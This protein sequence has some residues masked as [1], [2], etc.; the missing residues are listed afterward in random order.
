MVVC[1]LRKNSEFHLNDTTN[2]GS[3]SQSPLSAQHNSENVVSEIGIDQGEKAIDCNS[4]KSTRSYDSHSI[5]QMDSASDSY[6]QLT[7]E[8]TQMESSG[9]Q[10]VGL[11]V[12]QHVALSF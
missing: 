5:E 12:S 4:K 11:F 1:R 8:V 6:Q 3:S 10:K 9:H 7:P 2:R